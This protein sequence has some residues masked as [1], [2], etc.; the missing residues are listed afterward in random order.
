MPLTL[1]PTVV[2]DT[3]APGPH[4]E[5]LVSGINEN[6][7]PDPSITSATIWG[8]IIAGTYP[9]ITAPTTPSFWTRNTSVF[10]TSPASVRLLT[11]TN[12]VSGILRMTKWI[13]CTPGMTVTISG[14]ARV[15]QTDSVRVPVIRI[16]VRDSVGAAVTWSAS[17]IAWPTTVNAAFTFV[18]GTFTI[19]ANAVEF[20]VTLGIEGTATSAF[21]VYWDDLSVILQNGSNQITVYRQWDGEEAI[22]QGA[23]ETEVLGTTMLF[24][25]YGV[26]FGT[27]VIYKVV[28][29]LN[30]ATKELGQSG[31]VTVTVTN[32]VWISDP[33]SPQVALVVTPD[34][35]SFKRK[36]YSRDGNLVNGIGR[37]KPLAL[38]GIRQAA[39]KIP[40]NIMTYTD[41]QSLS[42]EAVLFN[43]DPV[44]IRSSS[45]HNL[46][47]LAFVTFSEINVEMIDAPEGSTRRYSMEATIVESPGV[48]V[49]V[50]IRT[51]QDYANE[52]TTYSGTT[53]ATY[54]DLMKG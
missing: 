45:N 27:T 22:L 18:T 31:V 3:V 2:M 46:P 9:G 53:Y 24:Y 39:S 42:L 49:L 28:T 32:T 44:M 23:Y 14:W 6:L 19:P 37:S 17:A 4:V 21:S 38:T 12:A 26:P 13:P 16:L 54:L 1:T 10:A 51:Y 8:T 52:F 29:A 47:S 50:P 7:V 15:T 25:D 36:S 5:L 43:T 20:Q 40:L 34:A 48:D 30:G 41:M 33:V 35:Q 11:T